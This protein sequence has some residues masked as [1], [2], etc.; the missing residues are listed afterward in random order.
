MMVRQVFTAS[1]T[2][3]KNPRIVEAVQQQRAFAL[4]NGRTL[5]FALRVSVLQSLRADAR[6]ANAAVGARSVTATGG[7]G[8]VGTGGGGG[9][10]SGGT[11]TPGS[12][13]VGVPGS[14]GTVTGGR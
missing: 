7:A 9:M 12:P 13:G 11:A 8:G 2:L 5:A 10:A 1:P 6:A 3:N 14:P 4:H